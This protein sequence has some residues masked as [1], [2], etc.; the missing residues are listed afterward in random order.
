MTRRR[1][2]VLIMLAM[3]LTIIGMLTMTILRCTIC[4]LAI[5][6]VMATVTILPTT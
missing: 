6:R 1:V 5:R 3:R 4:L 2:V